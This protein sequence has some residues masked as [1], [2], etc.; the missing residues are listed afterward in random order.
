MQQA[1]AILRRFVGRARAMTPA[2]AFAECGVSEQMAVRKAKGWPRFC[3][4]WRPLDCRRPSR[5]IEDAPQSSMGCSSISPARQFWRVRKE[6]ALLSG[7]DAA[8]FQGE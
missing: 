6:F 7:S 3:H 2:K 5:R 8:A 4:R 1:A